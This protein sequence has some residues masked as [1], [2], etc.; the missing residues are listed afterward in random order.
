MTTNA[1]F[2]FKASYANDC[3]VSK[4][5]QNSVSK[6][7]KSVDGDRCMGECFYVCGFFGVFIKNRK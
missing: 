1:P 3:H 5:V 4:V 7:K 6:I 2:Q